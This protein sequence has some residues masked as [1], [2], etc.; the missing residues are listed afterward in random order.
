MV[1]DA[2]VAAE[3]RGAERRTEPRVPVSLPVLVNLSGC[4]RTAKL[5][6][7]SRGGAM[8]ETAAALARGSRLVLSCGTIEANATVVWHDGQTFGLR[9]A[10]PVNDAVIRQQIDRSQAMASLRT[11]R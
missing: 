5:H 9:F 6:N 4:Q 3:R 2:A 1:G 7:L 10:A 8:V 11:V